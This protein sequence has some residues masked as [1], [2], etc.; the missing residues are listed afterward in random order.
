LP[1]AE[2]ARRLAH[3]S[4]LRFRIVAFPEGTRVYP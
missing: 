1:L 3:V 4:I 2:A